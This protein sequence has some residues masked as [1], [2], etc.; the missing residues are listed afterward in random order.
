MTYESVAEATDQPF[1]PLF[2]ALGEGAKPP[3][4]GRC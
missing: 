1:V 4:G 2:E 3:D